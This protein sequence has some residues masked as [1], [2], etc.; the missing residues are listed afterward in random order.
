[1][2]QTNPS[3]QSPHTNPEQGLTATEVQ[4]L[5]SEFGE[6]V[7][8]EQ[9]KPNIFQRIF[10]HMRDI[11]SLVLLFA[12]VL[13]TYLAA[14]TDSGWTKPAVITLIVISNV[15]ISLFQ[16]GRTEK[17]IQSL[18]TLSAQTVDV[19]RDGKRQTIPAQELVPGDILLLSAGNTVAADGDVLMTT[20]LLVEEAILTGESEPIEKNTTDQ[21]QVYSGTAV[22]QGT[23]TVLVTA[24]GM[25]T[26]L[27]RIANL[28]NTTKKI[29][30]PLVQRLNSLG[31]RLSLMAIVGGIAAILLAILLYQDSPAEAM[32]IGIGLAIAAVPESLPVIVTLSLT[33]GVRQM[34]RQNAIVRRITAVET[35]GN[36][37][38]IASDK[39]GTLT[40]NKM[41][42]VKSIA[43]SGTDITTLDAKLGP[44][45]ALATN[46]KLGETAT[47]DSGSPTEL[48]I[49]RFTHDQGYSQVAA[50]KQYPQVAED[51]FNSA[52]KTMAT[53]HK[54]EHGYLAIIKGAFDRLQFANA[55]DQMTLQSAHDRLTASG[56]RVLA[57][58]YQYF[59]ED[60]GETWA[61]KLSQLI[62]LGL[63]GIQ[64]PP[65]QEVAAAIGE[66]HQA[67]IRTVMITGDH[68]GTATAIAREIGILNSDGLVLSGA[69]L[70]EMDDATLKTKIDQVRV[71][72]RTTPTDKLRIVKIWQERGEVVAMT[73]DG[74][75]DAPALRQADVGIAMGIT[76]SDVAKSA[77]DMILVDDNF[78]TIIAAVR[79]GRTVYQNILKAVEF[80][81][82]VNFAQIFTLLAAVLIGWGA[83]LSAEQMLIINILAD[84]IPGFFLSQEPSEAGVMSFSPLNRNASIWSNGLAQRVIVRTV[85][86]VALILSI[87]ALGR[88]G[89]SNNNAALGMSMLFFVLAIGSVLDMFP[90]KT[91]GPITKR[92][93][94]SNPVLTWSVIG[95]MAVL[96]MIGLTPPLATLFGVVTLSASTWGIVLIAAVTP[97]MIVEGYKRQQHR[98]QLAAWVTS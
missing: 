58:G 29:E 50:L 43:P 10:Y 37:T 33:H 68:V 26:E 14:T 51:P 17:A 15:G 27:G 5:Q 79:Q 9:K 96:I 35:I 25:Q 19:K 45:W 36:V 7:L 40:Q 39:T 53:L 57:G 86:Y 16:E 52:K 41:T 61:T 18:Q 72:A 84:G 49:L 65:R 82:S 23:A 30:T 89:L 22:L 31:L 77:A 98:H 55:T 59:A 44:L 12:V 20:G 11:T 6:N 42:V 24:I 62:P 64:D 63:V 74:V 83:P 54:A 87:Y 70:A 88:F 1:M 91:R 48:A 90:I 32:M 95:T 46:A 78:A 21:H 75:N 38:V 97:M 2:T 81:V 3:L 56:L 76:G 47:T 28:L 92:T 66:A 80:L 60:P 71:F 8:V 67:G 34:A 93:F 69:E 94:T 4:Q 73:G 85:T 13:S